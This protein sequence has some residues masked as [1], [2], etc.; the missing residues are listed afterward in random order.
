MRYANLLPLLPLLFGSP[1][2]A[3][4][5]VTLGEALDLA[6]QQ[7]PDY[8]KAR[9]DADA[10]GLAAMAGRLWFLPTVNASLNFNG[11][12]NTNVTGTGTDGQPFALPTPVTFRSSSA[13]Q[14][15]S[16]SMTLFDGLRNL[17]TGRAAAARANATG[18]TLRAAALRLTA[19]VTRQFL[20][21]LRQ[22]RLIDV[23]ERLLTSQ[24][25]QLTATERLFRTAGANQVDVLGAQ[26]AVAQQ[27]QAL[28]SQRG[29]AQKAG[30]ELARVIGLDDITPLAAS[31]EL[32]DAFDPSALAAD[33]LVARAMAESPRIAQLGALATAANAEAGASYGARWPTITA[34]AGFSRSLS[35]PSYS[36]FG[37]L[38]PRNRSFGFGLQ[39][40]VPIF[41]RFQTSANIAGANARADNAAEDMRAG[42]LQLETDVRSALVDLRNA[43]Q[44][45]VLAERSADLSRT[46]QDLA[47][48]QYRLG[49]IGYQNLQQVIDGAA[50]AERQAVAARF[51]FALALVAI[52]ELVGGEVRP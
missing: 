26:V 13:S 30:L 39:V 42:Q 3:A 11:G 12:S 19:S 6:R 7:N 45:L 32:P 51:N 38:N 52:E 17:R 37:E 8:R 14:S 10:A 27:E 22:Q 24:R 34:N 15:L 20:T 21:S 47:Q 50:Q 40:Q 1:G 18:A 31:G 48:Q 2:L 16:A 49:A 28:A 43:H 35:V 41:T 4:Q 9:N 36:A 29:E 23:E 5:T 33:A 25:E 44:A 46:R